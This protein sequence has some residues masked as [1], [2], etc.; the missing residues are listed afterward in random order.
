[1]TVAETSRNMIM[2]YIEIIIT[3]NY[4]EQSY[5]LIVKVRNTEA[6][7]G[8]RKSL[9]FFLENCS[10]F[11]CYFWTSIASGDEGMIWQLS[12]THIL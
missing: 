8:S 11:S 10:Y 1:M 7:R 4:K 6:F 9:T 5:Q 12:D 3:V 2:N